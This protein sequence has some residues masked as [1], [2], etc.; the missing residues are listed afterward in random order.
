MSAA[1]RVNAETCQDRLVVLASYLFPD[2]FFA[3]NEEA[4]EMLLYEINML[5]N[6]IGIPRRLTELGV[7]ED[8]LPAIVADSRGGSMS[9]NPRELSDEE[10]MKFLS[11]LM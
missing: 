3:N 4:V 7:R 1:I 10:L 11:E 8:Q 6:A 2:S 9:G 5:C